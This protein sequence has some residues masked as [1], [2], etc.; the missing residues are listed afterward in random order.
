[1]AL[2]TCRPNGTHN[3]PHAYR[4]PHCSLHGDN[5]QPLPVSRPDLES[6]HDMAIR[7][8]AQRRDFGMEKYRTPLTAFNTRAQIQDAI[9]DGIDAV[10]YMM[11][12]RVEHEAALALLRRC[13]QTLSHPAP[14]EERSAMML[15]IEDFF[16]K[17][18]AS[19][20]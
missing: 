13:M 8:I 4:D 2:C 16:E 3:D 7:E 15:A 11:A 10:C 1:M 19:F 14:I 5:A 6:A 17:T 9:D 18:G 12:A 20:E